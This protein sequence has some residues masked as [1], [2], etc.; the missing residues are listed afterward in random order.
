MSGTATVAGSAMSAAP[1]AASHSITC[2]RQEAAVRHVMVEAVW[3]WV[4]RVAV[5]VVRV[6]V[7]VVRVAVG[8]LGCRSGWSGW[9]RGWSGWRTGWLQWV[10]GYWWSCGRRLCGGRWV[11]CPPESSLMFTLLSTPL[12]RKT[13]APRAPPSPTRTPDLVDLPADGDPL[14]PSAPQPL[15]PSAPRPLGPLA[16]AA[17]S[18]PSAPVRVKHDPVCPRHTRAYA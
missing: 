6:A 4:V 5:A 9:W 16:P 1:R 2:A 12:P 3:G 17:P 11:Q 10:A 14:T 8:V 7:A 15:S 13:F 18:A